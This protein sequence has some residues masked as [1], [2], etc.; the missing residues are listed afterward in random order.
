M[1]P[2]N[3]FVASRILRSFQMSLLA[4]SVSASTPKNLAV[5]PTTNRFTASCH[6]SSVAWPPAADTVVVAVVV[7][8]YVAVVVCAAAALCGVTNCCGAAGRALGVTASEDSLV[9]RAVTPARDGCVFGDGA[10]TETGAPAEEKAL[11]EDGPVVEAAPRLE[12][13]GLLGPVFL[14]KEK[15]GLFFTCLS[16]K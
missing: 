11:M 1:T 12:Q 16:Y 3:L 10:V 4:S 5:P 14:Q 6:A 2:P 7:A 15:E 9:T 13:W 8:S